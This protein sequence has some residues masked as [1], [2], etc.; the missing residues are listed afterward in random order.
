MHIAVSS[1]HGVTGP[2][3]SVSPVCVSRLSPALHKAAVLMRRRF[4][5]SMPGVRRTRLWLLLVTWAGP[6]SALRQP[7]RRVWHQYAWIEEDVAQAAAADLG[8]PMSLL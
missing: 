5:I 3:G 7:S 8:M 1:Q 2:R 6:C 4:N